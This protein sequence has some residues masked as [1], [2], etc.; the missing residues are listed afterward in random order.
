MNNAATCSSTAT[1]GFSSTTGRVEAAAE[2]A[3]G[4]DSAK[5]T[6]TGAA[7]T[8]Q[9][10]AAACSSS[11]LQ[12]PTQTLNPNTPPNPT[13]VVAEQLR[14]VHGPEQ[15]PQL[16]AAVDAAAAVAETTFRAPPPVPWRSVY[17]RCHFL[18]P[19]PR[20]SSFSASL[21]SSSSGNVVGPST[22][23]GADANVL[24][25]IMS[26]AAPALSPPP[27]D[28]ENEGIKSACAGS[29]DSSVAYHVEG[30]DAEQLASQQLP[31]ALSLIGVTPDQPP[32]IAGTTGLF[33]AVVETSKAPRAGAA[34]AGSAACGSSASRAGPIDNAVV[35]QNTPHFGPMLDMENESLDDESLQERM[36]NLSELRLNPDN[37]G[38]SPPPPAASTSSSG[39][40]GAPAATTIANTDEKQ[41]QLLTQ[42]NMPKEPRLSE[43]NLLPNSSS[44]FGEGHDEVHA[45][46][47]SPEC[48]NVMQLVPN[49]GTAKR[50]SPN[51]DTKKGGP[52]AVVS[53]L[54][55]SP[56]SVI[57]ANDPRKQELKFEQIG[58]SSSST[59]AIADVVTQ[60]EDDEE[61]KKKSSAARGIP[62]EQE[63]LPATKRAKIADHEENAAPGPSDATADAHSNMED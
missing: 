24:G 19:M 43:Q 46:A 11:C 40:A 41:I 27:E 2:T 55:G 39:A 53:D 36:M 45:P 32:Q 7:E 10:H 25:D 22:P 3:L 61:N 23:T 16:L 14:S 8:V 34:A 42:I 12:G 56:F 38:R 18:S 63:L 31:S 9:Q 17:D 58:G 51:I 48:T 5:E 35:T 60:D 1:A 37:Q 26:G 47:E 62:E 29:S 54:A 21:S 44:S 28:E 57:S 13:E 6:G 20:R 4:E 15:S 49:T 50:A 30:T 59:A 52:P 33:A